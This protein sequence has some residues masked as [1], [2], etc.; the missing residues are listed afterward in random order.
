MLLNEIV[1]IRVEASNKI[2]FGHLSRCIALCA[3]ISQEANVIFFT[4]SEDVVKKCKN[5]NI[6]YLKCSNDIEGIE[7]LKAKKI[8]IQINSFI[9]DCKE[10]YSP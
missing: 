6:D 10:S 4:N 2:G 8:D 5:L 1:I 3:S 9:V 7:L